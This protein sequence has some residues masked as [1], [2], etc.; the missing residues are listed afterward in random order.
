[1]GVPLG[2]YATGCKL[3]KYVCILVFCLHNNVVWFYA[4]LYDG[5]LRMF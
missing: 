1:M 4:V 3:E 5:N 2:H